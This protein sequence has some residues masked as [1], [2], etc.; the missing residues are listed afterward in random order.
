VGGDFDPANLAAGAPSGVD[1]SM[2]PAPDAI[3]GD[4]GIDA[5]ATH[6]VDITPALVESG[7]SIDI[8][9]IDVTDTVLVDLNGDG[10]L[11]LIV[12]YAQNDT[13]YWLGDGTGS[14]PESR[15]LGG[16]TA[17]GVT[18]GDIDGDGDLD[19]VLVYEFAAPRV[20][21]NDDTG[22]FTDSGQLLGGTDVYRGTCLI[23]LEGDGELDLFVGNS[24]DFVVADL[25]END[26][27]GTFIDTFQ[28]LAV[29]SPVTGQRAQ[30]GR[31]GGRRGV[32]A[33]TPGII[34]A[35]RLPAGSRCSATHRR[36]RRRRR[37]PAH[38]GCGRP[39]AWQAAS[40]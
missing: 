15:S 33:T 8:T 32:C 17:T 29:R 34:G 22:F 7:M 38:Q 36:S 25:Y 1:E 3:E 12:A 35:F 14:F 19:A 24:N 2:A 26:G 16:G 23:D 4:T 5:I 31:A 21:L 27:S 11:D 13:D 20:L 10:P 6:T 28:Q 37:A 30:P 18:L 39:H 9:K 40:A